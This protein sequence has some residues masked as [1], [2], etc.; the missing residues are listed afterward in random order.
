MYLIIGE[1][2][3]NN[4]TCEKASNY[5]AATG[6][7][8]LNNGQCGL[9]S[10]NNSRITIAERLLFAFHELQITCQDNLVWVN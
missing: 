3:K 5:L 6:Y 2:R 8:M 9:Q 7:F 1:R 4:H 10:G